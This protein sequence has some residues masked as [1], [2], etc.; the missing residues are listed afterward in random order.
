MIVTLGYVDSQ[1]LCGLAIPSYVTS[2]SLVAARTPTPVPTSTPPPTGPSAP[3]PI[4]QTATGT[5]AA[6]SPGVALL[7]LGRNYREAWHGAMRTNAGQTID[8][9]VETALTGD[10]ATTGL[11]AVDKAA[12]S[13]RR[14]SSRR[15]R[16]GR[17][18]RRRSP[19]RG[20]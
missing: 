16:C 6:I 3:P 1:P 2:A 9:Y 7:H 8:F 4:T 10:L 11:R 13:G 15:G 19:T 17:D 14:R 18:P 12:D 20:R 5:I